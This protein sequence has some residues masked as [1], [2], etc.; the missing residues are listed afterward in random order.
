[1][2]NILKEIYDLT[3]SK[4]VLE[5]KLDELW[6]IAEQQNIMSQ[7]AYQIEVKEIPVRT[8][9]PKRF[10]EEF[11]QETFNDVAKV[12]LKDAKQAVPE[13][14]LFTSGCIETTT[15]TTKS[16]VRVMTSTGVLK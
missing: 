6:K 9:V 2:R 1:M 12:S 16:V 13:G 8:I 11:G 3:E 4:K 5:K 15:R 7:G 10:L 14:R